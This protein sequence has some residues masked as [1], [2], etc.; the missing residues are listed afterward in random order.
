MRKQYCTN[1]IASHIVTVYIGSWLLF[2]IA[3]L[4][5]LRQITKSKQTLTIALKKKSSDTNKKAD[6]QNKA[7]ISRA[8]T[9]Q[10]TIAKSLVKVQF[11]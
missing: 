4:K 9:I 10:G 1:F 7:K 11:L 2:S 8:I 5:V 6:I 3:L